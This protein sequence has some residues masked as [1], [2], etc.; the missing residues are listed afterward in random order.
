MSFNKF[1]KGE[2]KK[3]LKAKEEHATRIISIINELQEICSK[4]GVNHYEMM[5]IL[6]NM[7][8]GLN[9]EV[10]KILTN[11]FHKIDEQTNLLTKHN[12]KLDDGSSKS[13]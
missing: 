6:C 8:G 2:K 11:N 3:M 5:D 10:A 12:I 4:R 13:T 9:K 7:Q 1:F